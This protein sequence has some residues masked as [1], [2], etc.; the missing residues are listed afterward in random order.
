MA[1]RNVKTIST[2][3]IV[4]Y[5]IALIYAYY[6]IEFKGPLEFL[7]A[8]TPINVPRTWFYY[9]PFYRWGMIFSTAFFYSTALT[10]LIHITWMISVAYSSL[11]SPDGRSL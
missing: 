2:V 1:R 3:W 9:Y 7:T 11:H 8:D 10:V 4:S 6:T 5:I